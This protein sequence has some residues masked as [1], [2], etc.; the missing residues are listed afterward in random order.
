MNIP[1]YIQVAGTI[2]RRILA[3]EYGNGDILPSS[4]QLEEEFKVRGP[5][6]DTVIK[7]NIEEL[8]EAYK[9]TLRW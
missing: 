4:E 9:R 6:G 1:F 5:D 7:E 3:D 2:R 8:K